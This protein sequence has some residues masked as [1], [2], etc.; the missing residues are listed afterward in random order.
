MSIIFRFLINASNRN[1]MDYF[2]VESLIKWY[3]V[4]EIVRKSSVKGTAGQVAVS[5]SL[6]RHSHG[7]LDCYRASSKHINNNNILNN[8]V[9][10]LN[11]WKQI[12]FY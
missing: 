11:D 12:S 2:Y 6:G 8:H 10:D 7:D 9:C 5:V 3:Y 1:K 4:K